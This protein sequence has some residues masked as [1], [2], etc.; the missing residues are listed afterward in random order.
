MGATKY[1]VLQQSSA[2]PQFPPR[3]C[4]SNAADKPAKHEVLG[5]AAYGVGPCIGMA[6]LQVGVAAFLPCSVRQTLCCHTIG[7]EER[8]L[9]ASVSS[10]L[11]FFPAVQNVERPRKQK[12]VLNLEH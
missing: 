3:L 8:W 10:P 2:V 1:A 11:F 9:R 5:I 4:L 7:K 6:A 12:Q